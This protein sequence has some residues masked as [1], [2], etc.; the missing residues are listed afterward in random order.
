VRSEGSQTFA[1]SI[2][3]EQA[4]S[5]MSESLIEVLNVEDLVPDD[6]NANKGTER[7]R[8]VVRNSIT[9]NGFGRSILLDKNNRIIGGNKSVEAASKA[10]LKTV[11]VIE[12]SGDEIIAVK[13]VDVD[14]DSETGRRLAISDNRASELGLAWDPEVL[15]QL[16]GEGMDFSS[17]FT[18]VELQ[19]LCDSLEEE[20][21]DD[22][23]DGLDL[24]DEEVPVGVKQF[25]L[26]ISEEIYQQFC[27]M[28]D[29]LQEKGGY[30]SATDCIVGVVT[31]AYPK[32]A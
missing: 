15:S 4:K 14:L 8:D 25:N 19:K 30:E 31:K 21:P 29:Y 26:F 20:M 24:D 18:E 23:D 22:G 3:A 6:L 10:G 11:R 32:T 17:Y 7:G 1:L 27:D 16:T 2:I 9:E 5:I 12:T 13:R 28:V